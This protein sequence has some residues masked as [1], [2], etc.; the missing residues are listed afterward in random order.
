MM[1]EWVVYLSTILYDDLKCQ[2]KQVV[3][4]RRRRFI[5]KTQLRNEHNDSKIPV[6]WTIV[7]NEQ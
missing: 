1:L 6:G 2:I 7:R 3:R 4:R 5:M